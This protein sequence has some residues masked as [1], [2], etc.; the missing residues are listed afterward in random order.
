MFVR[1]LLFSLAWTLSFLFVDA[2]TVLFVFFVRFS[3]RVL[4]MGKLTIIRRPNPP[5]QCTQST[6]NTN[7]MGI[8]FR[9]R[10]N[11]N[12]K[13]RYPDFPL[14]LIQFC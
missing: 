2:T 6:L 12:K 4:W 5:D 13:G 10:F 14:H 7:A 9:H 8:Y 3:L 11:A 1:I